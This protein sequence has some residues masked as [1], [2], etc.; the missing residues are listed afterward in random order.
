MASADLLQTFLHFH[1][2]TDASSVTNLPSVISGLSSDSLETSSHSPKWINR[3]NALIHSREPAARW[4][5]ITLALQTSKLSSNVLISSAE[6][7]VPII[8]PILSRN[9]SLAVWK[10]SIRLLAFIFTS[11][12]NLAEFQRQVVIPNVLKL[13]SALISLAEKQRNEELKVLCLNVLAV[14]VPLYPTLHRQ[15]A[16]TLS[17]MSLNFLNGSPSSTPG[18]LVLS[19]ARLHACLHVTGGKVGGV[20]LWRKSVDETV[21]FCS[22]ALEIL[23]S[24]YSLGQLAPSQSDPLISIPLNLDRLRCGV[25]LLCHLLRVTVDRPVLVPVQ[26][27]ANLCVEMLRVARKGALSNGVDPSLRCMEAAVV[28]DILD[29]GCYLTACLSNCVR[30][31]FTPHLPRILDI[32]A[33]HLEQPTSIKERLPLIKVI[34]SLLGSCLPPPEPLTSGRIIKANLPAIATLL[35]QKAVEESSTTGDIGTK[36]GKKRARN[37]EGDEV[38]K[39]SR[40]TLCET[41]EDTEL[42]VASLDALPFLLR[43]PNIP[44]YLQSLSSRLLLSLLLALPKLSA[45]SV[46]RDPNI[47]DEVLRRVKSMCVEFASGSSAVLCKSLPLVVGAISDDEMTRKNVL[48]ES[49]ERHE[50]ILDLM[51]HP[52]LPP[53]LRSL[54]SLDTIALCRSEEGT[55]ERKTRESLDLRSICEDKESE[56]VDELQPSTTAHETL[57]KTAVESSQ[58]LMCSTTDTPV[59]PVVIPAVPIRPAAPLVVRPVQVEISVAPEAPR[60]DAVSDASHPQDASIDPDEPKLPPGPGPKGTETIPETRLVP[61]AEARN[62][63]PPSYRSTEPTRMFVDDEDED[64]DIEMPVLNMESDTDSE[65]E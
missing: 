55:E 21:A 57:Q 64:G 54:P 42:V 34:P 10:A 4:A 8:L 49:S 11:T 56:E 45:S 5:G 63:E 33:Y 13:S 24:T 43:V 14:V 30:N 2:A 9:E 46:A 38:F 41:I 25:E 12:T 32:I 19:A 51:L 6:G 28:P 59:P 40:D 37:Y 16:S 3:V 35:S 17:T 31:K 47:K 50:F 23:R 29:L 62:T 44:A 48:P 36:K 15:L 26:S 7:W 27:L 58:E 18:A 65:A 39:V 53:L 1:L 60:L 52:R 61:P 20:T 22:S